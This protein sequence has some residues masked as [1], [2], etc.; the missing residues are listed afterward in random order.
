MRV[1]LESLAFFIVFF[2]P[3][4]ALAAVAWWEGHLWLSVLLI[5]GTCLYYAVVIVLARRSWDKRQRI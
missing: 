2:G 5:V 1:F 4:L 3:S